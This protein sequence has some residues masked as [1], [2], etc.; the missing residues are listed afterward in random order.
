MVQ[1]R[2]DDVGQL[3]D[4]AEHGRAGAAKIVTGPPCCAGIDLDCLRLAVPVPDWLSGAGCKH[5]VCR[6]DA[7]VLARLQQLDSLV[8][9]RHDMGLPVL[10]LRNGP[11]ASREVHVTP[12]R[13]TSSRRARVKSMNR[14]AA[15]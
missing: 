3:A 15:A 9:Q 1:R 12:A 8:R 14:M 10:R 4:L 13:A 6:R 5:R 11:C 7:I 2:F